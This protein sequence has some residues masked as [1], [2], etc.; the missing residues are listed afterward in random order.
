MKR[1][2]IGRTTRINYTIQLKSCFVHFFG[3]HNAKCN[4]KRKRL[5]WKYLNSRV[6]I[7]IH[8]RRGF[9]IQT[10][11]S[12]KRTWHSKRMKSFV[13]LFRIIFYLRHFTLVMQNYYRITF[14]YIITITIQRVSGLN[15]EYWIRFKYLQCQD[16]IFPCINCY[17]LRTK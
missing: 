1:L 7:R 15:F 12:F 13:I 9:K 10:F 11:Y 6:R 14:A 5:F 3:F 17:F 2:T 8:N 4:Y 16:R